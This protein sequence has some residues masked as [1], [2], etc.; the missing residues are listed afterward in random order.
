MCEIYRATLTDADQN[1][2]A[3]KSRLPMPVLAVGSEHFI[4][5]DNERQMREV[6]DDVR[7]VILPWGD[8]L[9]EE[10]PTSSSGITCDSLRGPRNERLRGP[11]RPAG[12][13]DG[14][15]FLS[16]G[17]NHADETNLKY[18]RNIDVWRR[19]YGSR[20]AWIRDGV[21]ADL[22]DWGFTTLGWTRSTSA[23]AGVRPSTG[24]ATRSTSAT[25][26]PWPDGRPRWRG[27]PYV[28]QIRVQEIE[29][30]NGHPAF[31]PIGDDFE[32]VA[33][34]T[35]PHRAGA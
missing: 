33:A 34:T 31:R 30:W 24:S 8:Q 23:A 16:L 28:A 12:R 5:A 17:V 27:L 3:A 25:P 18:P 22:H 35:S 6:A 20:D 4:G 21:V 15:P 11:R 14:T 32:V 19:K 13:P 9:A 29:D 10:S 26:R 7:G 2:E 1:R